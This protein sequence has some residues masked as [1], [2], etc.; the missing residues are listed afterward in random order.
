[1]QVYTLSHMTPI[2][3]PLVRRQTALGGF[4][5]LLLVRPPD[6]HLPMLT[7]L[8]LVAD[9]LLDDDDR[10]H[11]QP[12]HRR[13]IHGSLSVYFPLMQLQIT[14]T[15]SLGLPSFAV[16][17]QVLP[18]S[19]EVTLFGMD[20]LACSLAC[21]TSG[22]MTAS[23]PGKFTCESL[24]PDCQVTFEFDDVFDLPIDNLLTFSFP[25]P[26]AQGVRLLA[27]SV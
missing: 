26:H 10:L 21:N 12:V 22:S 13:S 20:I 25:T 27:F 9:F 2:E 11:G 23:M 15:T 1:M 19:I 4:A 14:Q 18:A 16:G 24:G 7:R 8:R 6:P 3:E 17:S 5:T